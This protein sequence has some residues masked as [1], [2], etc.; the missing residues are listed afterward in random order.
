MLKG[1]WFVASGVHRDQ[2]EPTAAVGAASTGA[3]TAVCLPSDVAAF[4]TGS[5]L[6]IG[7]RKLA[8]AQPFT[9]VRTEK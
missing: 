6:G 9:Q 7:R 2:G 8:G 4:T 5:T 1:S 3:S